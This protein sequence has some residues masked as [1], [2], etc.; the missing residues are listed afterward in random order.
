MIA[1]APFTSDDG[2]TAIIGDLQGMPIPYSQIGS[3]GHYAAQL[4]T[5][6]RYFTDAVFDN[7]RILRPGWLDHGPQIGQTASWS[8]DWSNYA[9]AWKPGDVPT[10]D[11]TGEAVDYENGGHGF[12]FPYDIQGLSD[13]NP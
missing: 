7:R 11:P 9:C 4:A 6:D 2:K 12:F 10:P 8:Y 1:L 13:L 3:S 5:V